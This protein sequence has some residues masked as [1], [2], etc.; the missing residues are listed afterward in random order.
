MHL[1]SAKDSLC[2]TGRHFL[3]KVPHHAAPI[4]GLVVERSVLDV[5]A[6]VPHRLCRHPGDRCRGRTPILRE[7]A[8]I[9]PI[10]QLPRL[11]LCQNL[12]LKIQW[13]MIDLDILPPFGFLSSG[14]R[15]GRGGFLALGKRG[16]QVTST[17]VA[18]SPHVCPSRKP[19]PRP[20]TAFSI[21]YLPHSQQ[22]N[23]PTLPLPRRLQGIL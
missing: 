15:T 5:I 10:L 20:V 18:R 7:H 4:R 12:Y 8:V 1:R 14:F 22:L 9:H 3:V 16:N 13:S 17:L 6:Q 2:R 23:L 11:L 19:T 21:I